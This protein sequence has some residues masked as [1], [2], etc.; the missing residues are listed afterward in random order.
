MLS[1]IAESLFWIGRYV[2]RADDTARILDVHLQM[3][4]EDAHLSELE[5]CRGLLAVMG[6]AP[7]G[8]EKRELTRDLVVEQ[9]AFD[10]QHS[11]S[12]TGAL[13]AARENARRARETISAELWECLNTTWNGVAP[14][15]RS[16]TTWHHFFNWVRERAALISG[17]ADSTMRHDDAWRDSGLYV[18]VHQHWHHRRKRPHHRDNPGKHHLCG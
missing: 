2:E 16:A 15:R 5:A 18:N 4:L 9:L 17:V 14:T 10:V 12:I 13:S 6:V 1:R 7:D 8:G 11:S 3:L